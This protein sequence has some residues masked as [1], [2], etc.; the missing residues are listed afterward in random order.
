MN[1]ILTARQT[2]P[3]GYLP[4][5]DY[6]MGTGEFG[7]LVKIQ[8]SK[9]PPQMIAAGSGSIIGK[10][11][12]TQ[13]QWRRSFR[14]VKNAKD[15]IEYL[16]SAFGFN[17][18]QLV[19]ILKVK[20]PTICKWLENKKLNRRSQERLDIIYSSF[21][22]WGEERI[23]RV[24]GYLYKKFGKGLSLH[25]ILIKESIDEALAKEYVLKIKEMLST[26]KALS[27]KRNESLSKAGFKPTS[28][29]QREKALRHLIRRM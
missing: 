12:L 28:Q 20:R 2:Y 14:K 9:I 17:V 19:T 18:S 13:E 24:G 4:Q 1:S 15:Q 27:V 6:F 7:G 11:A 23:G 10:E 25:D 3:T 5:K 21:S 26:N 29:E 16:R 8:F 22:V